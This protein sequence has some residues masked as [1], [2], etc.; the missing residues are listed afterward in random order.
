MTLL[1]AP[2]CTNAKPQQSGARGSQSD[3]DWLSNGSCG[4]TDYS[5]IITN[6]DGSKVIRGK[7]ESESRVNGRKFCFLNTKNYDPWGP[8]CQYRN[9]D[10]YCLNFDVCD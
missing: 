4:C 6:P 5:T 2:Q 3:I 8:C 9:S 10:D 1:V 7:C